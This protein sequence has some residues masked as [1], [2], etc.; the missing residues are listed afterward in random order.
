[1]ACCQTNASSVSSDVITPGQEQRVV[2]NEGRLLAGERHGPVSLAGGQRD[3]GRRKLLALG[4]AQE[5]LRDVLGSDDDEDRPHE[6]DILRRLPVD[7]Q[8]VGTALLAE[9]ERGE[10]AVTRHR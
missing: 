4:G 7:V 2:D 1:M 9:R 8:D 3:R 6:I 10:I 5:R